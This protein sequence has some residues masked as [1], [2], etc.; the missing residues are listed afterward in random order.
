M[1]KL[2]IAAAIVCAAALSQAATVN[3]VES[4]A[5]YDGTTT[6][7][8]LNGDAVMLFWGTDAASIVSDFAAGKFTGGGKVATGEVLSTGKIDESG[9][10]AGVTGGLA[11]QSAFYA[12]LKGDNLFVSDVSEAI[13]DGVGQAYDVSWS[14][15]AATSKALPADASAGYQGAGWYTAVPEPTSGLLL[16]LGVAGLALR[17]RRA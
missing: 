7:T 8:K 3:W 12:I 13:W 15:A 17:R 11:G 14:T 16:L 10:Y 2:M 4:K 5:L 9:D 6:T 1:K